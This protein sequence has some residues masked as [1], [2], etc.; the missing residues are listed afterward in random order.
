M[1]KSSAVNASEAAVRAASASGGGWSCTAKR[2]R[3]R[4]T[5][6]SSSTDITDGV[7]AVVRQRGVREGIVS[8]W[9]MH[10]TC[11]V[12][13]NESQKALHADIKRLLET[14]VDRDADW[15]HNDPDHSDCDRLNADA[16]LRAMLLGHSLT[17]QISGGELVL[18]QWQRVLVAELDGPRARTL[19]IQVMGIDL[20]DTVAS[21]IR[22]KADTRCMQRLNALGLADI[23]EKLDAGE[24]LGVRRRRASVRVPGSAGRRLAGESRAREAARRDGPTTT[25]TSGSRRPTSA[26]R[27]V[28]SARS[29][30]CGPAI[31][32][33][34]RCRSSRPGTSCAQRAA[35]A[36][37]RSPRRQRPASRSAVRLLP[38]HAAR[39]QADPARTFISSASPRSRSR[40]S[41]ISTR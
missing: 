3:S 31:P 6:A 23:V 5:S 32:G 19:R 9:S 20:Q 17:L 7:L 4:P 33:P 18:G 26:W 14:M 38:R 13:I 37:D 12:F 30:G 22:R 27:A 28:C 41:P 40:S 24:R 35:S 2:S 11:S 29:R 15:M 36:A 21:A 8:L 25:S 34:T 1:S 16:H 10:T 39:L